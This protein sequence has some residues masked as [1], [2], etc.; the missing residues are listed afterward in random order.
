MNRR[1][2]LAVI[3]GLVGQPAAAFAVPVP[4]APRRIDLVNAHTGERFSGA[5]RDAG[6]PIVSAMSDLDS[7]LRDFHCGAVTR[8]DV[9]VIDFLAAVLSAVGEQK[10][11]I[12]SA[13]RTPATNAMLARTM[14][15][16][17]DNSQHMYGRALDIYL[18]ARLEAAMTAARAMKRGGVGWYP[19]SN[20]IHIDT[21]PVRNWTLD[22]GG[23]TH[24]LLG[25]HYFRIDGT[26]IH[27][28]GDGTHL[29]PG[30]QRFIGQ[31]HPLTVA[32]RLELHRELAHAEYLARQR[33]NR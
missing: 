12:L 5:Y 30:A 14:F 23:L 19:R 9:G 32:Q 18:P 22:Q 24:L 7:F 3:A 4:S 8:M 6:G 25:N 11:T 31:G 28:V 29:L 33:L 27:V 1:L 10:A 17:A 26:G 13:Y 15:G 20:F 16:V 2:F 21:G